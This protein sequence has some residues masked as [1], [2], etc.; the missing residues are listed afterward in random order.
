MDIISRLQK[1]FK[2]EFG[3]QI[4]SV[5]SGAILTVVLTQV[6]SADEYGTLFLTISLL[7]IIKI[8]SRLGI[9]KSTSRYITKYKETQPDQV[10]YVLR[11]GTRLS[12]ITILFTCVGVLF[13]R[14]SIARILN[15]PRLDRLLLVGILF[16]IF[17]T[18]SIF[19]RIILQGFENIEAGAVL[20]SVDRGTRLVFVLGFVLLGYG[21]LGA[22]FG[23]IIASAIAAIIGMG[24]IHSKYYETPKDTMQAGL[25]RKIAEYMVPL[26]VTSSANVIDKKVD[27]VLVGFFLNPTAVAY[28]TLSKQVVTF[29]QAP[30]SAMGFTLSP[31]F[32]AENAKGNGQTAARIYE[33]ALVSA[34]LFYIPA[35]AGLALIAEPLV[36][37]VFGDEY[38]GAVP[39]I[40]VMAGYAVVLSIAI[41]TSNSLDY[42]GRARD[43]A[44]LKGVTSILNA[45]FNIILIPR[46]GV[47]GAA[48]STVITFAMFTMGTV[49][50]MSLEFDLR[51][52]WILNQT[53]Y[54]II[55]TIIMSLSVFTVT[56][57]VSGYISLILVICLGVLIW[58]SFSS[59]FGL[60]NLNDVFKL[61]R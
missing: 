30:M 8:F 4:I 27:T 24:Y 23:Y 37:L 18:L 39:V 16:I 1:Q 48:F 10:P 51:V 20:Q 56:M 60:I 53:L 46:I 50:V 29:I 13:T 34:L 54:I 32:E 59:L 25:R 11:F 21:S 42:L 14:Q 41:L 36:N 43:R 55:V 38:S 52:L 22:L 45:I 19:A 47:V 26:T 3:G 49:Y 40:Q 35:A 58:I 5:F 33:R 31:V 9:D 7:G 57:Y 12:L 2:I 28:Y 61:F 6:L 17:S 44:I 15:E